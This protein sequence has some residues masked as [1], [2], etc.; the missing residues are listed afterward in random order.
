MW[1]EQQQRRHRSTSSSRD[2]SRDLLVYPTLPPE[3]RCDEK[4]CCQVT[5][6]VYLCPQGYY[7]NDDAD[8]ILGESASQCCKQGSMGA[9]GNAT[10]RSAHRATPPEGHTSKGGPAAQLV[11]GAPTNPQKQERKSEEGESTEAARTASL[12][13]ETQERS[14]YGKLLPRAADGTR[15]G[16]PYK[17]LWRAQRLWARRSRDSQDHQRS[18]SK[19]HGFVR[20]V[21]HYL[22]EKSMVQRLKNYG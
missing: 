8:S 19:K 2:K 4:T 17:S 3:I 14:F 9:S 22:P 10:W 18:G 6:A 13:Q 20:R 7:I 1:L 12:A 15:F 11:G 5:C 16:E 21:A